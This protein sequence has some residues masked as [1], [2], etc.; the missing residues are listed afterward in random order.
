MKIELGQVVNTLAEAINQHKEITEEAS[1]AIGT[2]TVKGRLYQVQMTLEPIKAK[3]IAAGQVMS[4][5]KVVVKD[6]RSLFPEEDFV[7]TE[8]E[9]EDE[10]EGL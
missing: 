9:D 5:G 1:V 10:I 2:V 3:H 6:I 8:N 4:E 7:E